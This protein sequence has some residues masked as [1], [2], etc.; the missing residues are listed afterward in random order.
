MQGRTFFDTRRE[1]N[2]FVFKTHLLGKP[3]IRIIGATNARKI[4]MSENSLVE[5]QWPRSIQLL[6]GEGSLTLSGGKVHTIRKKAIH[7]AFTSDALTGYTILTQ[8]TIRKHI[9]QWCQTG[10]ILGYK[11]FRSLAFELSCRVLLGFEMDKEEKTRLLESFETFMSNL[12]S[13][14]VCIPG[15]GLYKVHFFAISFHYFSYNDVNHK[16]LI[17]FICNRYFELFFFFNLLINPLRLYSL[18]GRVK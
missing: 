7:R 3:T 6:L 11:E 13:L 2:G 1:E 12:F 18:T 14:P 10:F 17:H 16:I 15:L 4:L 9:R 8:D 5:S